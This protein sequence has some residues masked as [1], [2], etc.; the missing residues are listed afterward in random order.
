MKDYMKKEQVLKLIKNGEQVE[1]IRLSPPLQNY[2]YK[3]NGQKIRSN[4]GKFLMDNCSSGIFEKPNINI[5][6]S[7]SACVYNRN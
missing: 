6:T 4:L 5:Y 3:A 2:I 1:I 7:V